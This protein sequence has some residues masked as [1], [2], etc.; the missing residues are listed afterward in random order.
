[1]SRPLHVRKFPST[2]RS[3]HFPYQVKTPNVSTSTRGGKLLQFKTI[4]NKM[5]TLASRALLPAVKLTGFLHPRLE[6]S[7]SSPSLDE[8]VPVRE[9]AKTSQRHDAKVYS[10]GV[11]QRKPRFHGVLC[12]CVLAS[13]N[14][15]G[16]FVIT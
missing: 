16:Y 3:S 12:V 14:N 9:R 7:L 2:N 1:M 10:R 13:W 6:R 4:S 5:Y 15:P 8:F 11:R